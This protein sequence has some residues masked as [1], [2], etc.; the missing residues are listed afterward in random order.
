MWQVQAPEFYSVHPK[1]ISFNF[2][3]EFP[4]RP[5]FAAYNTA[6]YKLAKFLVTILSPLATNDYN[7]ENSYSFVNSISQ[8]NNADKLYMV[9]FDV[10][11][12]FTNTPVYET[13]D[14]CLKYLFP[15]SNSVVLGLSK[16][17][18]KT[19]LEH[20][21]LN[22]FF[23]FNSKLCKQI[24]G[25][26]QGLPLGPTYANIFMCHHE[27]NWLQNCPLNFKPLF[28]KRYI[29]DNFL[30]FTNEQ[31]A[32]LFLQYLNNQHEN[33]TFTLECETNNAP[34]FLDV[35]VSRE[36]NKFITSVFRKETFSGQGTSFLVFVFTILNWTQLKLWYIG[37]IILA[38]II[39]YFI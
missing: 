38:V 23:L 11:K 1:F 26:G 10:E 22:S 6:S 3:T 9:T 12:L 14:I 20:S 33:I 7:I 30:L 21:V 2:S 15:A 24:D 32:H 19:L 34:S 39:F 17:F 36:N 13:I 4:F 28:Y 31:H 18:F 16:D 35:K 25:L 5:I 27:K 37:P 8:V 29:D